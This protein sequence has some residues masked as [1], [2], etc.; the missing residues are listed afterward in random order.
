MKVPLPVSYKVNFLKVITELFFS[1]RQSASPQ[2]TPPCPQNIK[3]D[4]ATKTLS[5]RAPQQ[6]D[7]SLLFCFQP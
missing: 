7:V 3:F 4:F 2:K 5:T 6:N 1:S